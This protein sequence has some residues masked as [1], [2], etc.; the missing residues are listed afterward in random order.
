M[1]IAVV[2]IRAFTTSQSAQAH[3]ILFQRIFEFATLDTGLPPR[4]AHIHGYGFLLWIADSH[5]GQALGTS[6]VFC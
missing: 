2:V 3:L 6:M 4:F 1:F 5:K